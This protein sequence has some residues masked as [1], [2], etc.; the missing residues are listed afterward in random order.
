MQAHKL[1]SSQAHANKLAT[2]GTTGPYSYSRSAEAKTIGGFALR[3]VCRSSYLDVMCVTLCLTLMAGCGSSP[4][5][6]GTDDL[7]VVNSSSSTNDAAD[8]VL[9][10]GIVLPGEKCC[11]AFMLDI[12]AVMTTGDIL[13]VETSCDCI[14]V[15]AKNITL[16][17]THG[18]R[19]ALGVVIDRSDE[20][21]GEQPTQ[22]LG[23][24]ISIFTKYKVNRVVAKV[25]LV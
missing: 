25:T 10:C 23:V 11:M 20:R 6:S 4:A 19:V 21:E 17:S 22:S 3:A 1:T 7:P 14:V 18:S 16:S 13:K 15:T 12:P 9:D 2:G 24:N 5:V 8:V